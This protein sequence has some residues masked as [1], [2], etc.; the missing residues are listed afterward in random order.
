[1]LAKRPEGALALLQGPDERSQR[2]SHGPATRCPRQAR[3]R[4][5]IVAAYWSGVA[6]WNVHEYM[7]DTMAIVDKVAPLSPPPLGQPDRAF[8]KYYSDAEQ[9]RKR[10][11]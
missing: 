10:W 8:S 5:G 4:G 11:P 7:S 2:R 1:G 3:V 6:D 9:A